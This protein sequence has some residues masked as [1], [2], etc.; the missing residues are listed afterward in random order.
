MLKIPKDLQIVTALVLLTLLFVLVP[1]LNKT[2]VRVI[3]GIMMVLFLPG[4]AL[5]ASLFPRKGDLDGIERFALSFGL[6]IAVVPLL[7]L[8]LNYTPF[9]I[10]LI[11]IIVTLSV[12]TLALVVTAHLRRL[13]LPEEERFFVPFKEIYE[14]FKAEIFE[15]PKSKVDKILTIFLIISIFLAVCMLAYVIV[16]PKK[17]E[18]FT[19]FYILGPN[20]SA[21]NYPTELKLGDSGKVILGIVNHEYETINYTLRIKLSNETLI[22]KTLR[23]DHNETFE[24]PIIFTP[25]KKGKDLKLEFLL[26][27]ENNFTEPYRE[28]HLWINVE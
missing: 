9:G 18:R 23:L 7:G 3:L 13:K 25:N 1:P 14:S 24:E 15:K 8:V 10:R 20:G 2:P 19:E 4:Y 16:T 17:G 5:I 22:E 28:T 26:Y 21:K 12:F 6:S 27:K 11:P